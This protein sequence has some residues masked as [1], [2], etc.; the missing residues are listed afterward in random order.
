LVGAVITGLILLWLFLPE[1]LPVPD[2]SYINQKNHFAMTAPTGWMILTS[3][4]Y[5]EIF[6]KLGDRFPKSLQHGLEQQNIE[7]GFLKPLDEPDF[8]PSINV[9]V[10]NAEIP[11]LDESQKDEATKALTAE[12]TRVLESYKLESSELTTVDELTSLQFISRAGL[13]VKTADAQQTY[14]ENSMGWRS[15]STQTPAQWQ[16][17]DLKMIQT[18]VPGRKKGYI[19]TCT[20]EASKFQVYKAAFDGAIESFRVT[21]RPARFGPILMG[22]IQGGLIALLG[23]LLYYLGMALVAFIRG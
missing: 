7:M 20:S 11:D 4:N 14:T 9:V 13:K 2:G 8:S 5:K 15:Y 1:G 19:I 21:Q 16:T 22:G 10:I 6:E 18:L 23:Y 12:F 17:Y 3:D